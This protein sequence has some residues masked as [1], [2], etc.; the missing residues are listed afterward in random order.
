M[1][2]DNSVFCTMHK[3][4]IPNHFKAQQQKRNKQ[5]RT[6]LCNPLMT[7]SLLEVGKFVCF[8]ERGHNLDVSAN[9]WNAIHISKYGTKL[10]N[11][12]LLLHECAE[13]AS[14]GHKFYFGSVTFSIVQLQRERQPLFQDFTL[15]I[16]HV[17]LE[18]K[19]GED[20]KCQAIKQYSFSHWGYMWQ[21]N[22]CIIKWK[23]SI[24]TFFFFLLCHRIS[25]VEMDP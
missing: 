17:L 23:A 8:T 3:E 16:S 22:R 14:L 18:K 15:A 7:A 12:G 25:Q 10:W 1:Y 4:S 5:Q 11:L 24:I 20:Y 9:G 6:W 2:K 21:L 13:K 19:E